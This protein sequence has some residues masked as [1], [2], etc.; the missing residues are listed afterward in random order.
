MKQFYKAY[1]KLQTKY[2]Y[3]ILLLRWGNYYHSFGNSARV[4]SMV[5]ESPGQSKMMN[6]E[7]VFFHEFHECALDRILPKCIKIGYRV[8]IADHSKEG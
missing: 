8:A 3:A 5:S 7:N 1:K 6:D 4:I 2:P